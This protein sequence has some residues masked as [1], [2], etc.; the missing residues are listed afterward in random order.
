M[1]TPYDDSH[2]GVG[3]E[4]RLDDP[5]EAPHGTYEKGE[6][7]SIGALISDI[8]SDLSTL[9]RQ[10]LDL[11]KAEARQS[12]TRAGKGVGM[13]GGAGLA[14]YFALLFLSIAAW[15]GLGAL[16]HNHGWSAVIIAV[17]WAIIAAIL[18]S[19]GRKS[20]K[21]IDGLPRTVETAKKVPG[22]L[23]GNDS[24]RADSNRSEG[25]A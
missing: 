2:L 24:D 19:M 6:V 14:G 13:L 4:D 25:R 12:A 21:D 1:S 23:K 9:I 15:W 8:S 3:G 11:A 10:E 18:A 22:A 7:S 20:M 17:I 16:I 5:I